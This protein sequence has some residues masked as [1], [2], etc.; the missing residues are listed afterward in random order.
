MR[1]AVCCESRQ[2]TRS[3]LEGVAL[4]ADWTSDSARLRCT[5][6]TRLPYIGVHGQS[7]VSPPYLLVDSPVLRIPWPPDRQLVKVC[8][9]I[10]VSQE[11]CAVHV[12]LR[13]VWSSTAV[14]RAT[15]SAPCTLQM[16]CAIG[17]SPHSASLATSHTSHYLF[18]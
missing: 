1:S 15:V 12:C 16:L 9:A 17:L 11:C 7:P 14:A 6:L 10:V 13:V 18:S 2:Q 4:T 3:F 8:L 5:T